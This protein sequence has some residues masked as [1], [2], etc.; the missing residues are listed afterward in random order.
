MSKAIDNLKGAL[1]TAGDYIDELE[2]ELEE[3]EEYQSIF[4]DLDHARDCKDYHDEMSDLFDDTYDAEQAKAIAEACEWQG[5]DDVSDVE[6][7]AGELEQYRNLGDF[8]EVQEAVH[9][10]DGG[11]RVADLE[12]ELADAKATIQKLIELEDMRVRA[13]R[14]LRGITLE[15]HEIDK[16]SGEE[17]AYE[18]GLNDGL[19]LRK[20]I[21]HPAGVP[22]DII[23]AP[24]DKLGEQGAVDLDS[25]G[26]D[27]A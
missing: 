13:I 19:I 3:L 24:E 1:S 8:D 14:E 10:S 18:V 6:D 22:L 17:Q 12:K 11:T 5:W 16:T 23:I 25:I 26:N 27:E 21:D 2:A 4:D 15:Q 20:Q 7:A 9:N